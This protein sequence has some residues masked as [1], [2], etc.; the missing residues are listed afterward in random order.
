M[1]GHFF[2]A[3]DRP[4]AWYE[5]ILANYLD[6]AFERVDQLLA[7]AK[8]DENGCVVSTTAQPR[9]VRFQGGGRIVLIALSTAC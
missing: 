4:Q 8:R 6:E 2:A 7:A 5:H 1:D 3:K 9:K